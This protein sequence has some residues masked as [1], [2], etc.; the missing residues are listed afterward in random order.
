MNLTHIAQSPAAQ[1]LSG[2]VREG[3]LRLAAPLPEA[4]V[5]AFERAHG[6]RLPVEYRW[7][8]TQLGNGGEGPP[9]YG[10]EPLSDRLTESV[11]TLAPESNHNRRLAQPFPGREE[12]WSDW[13][14]ERADAAWEEH[15]AGR[16]LLGTDGCA[17]LWVLAVAGPAAGQVWMLS[18]HGATPG[19]PVGFLE[20]YVHGLADRPPRKH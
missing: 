16:L 3:R 17:L 14:P 20:W 19:Q 10:V 9:Y 15:E 2:A 12:F 8:V 11:P 13:E 6:V 4:D 5:E 7:L 1:E 18:Q